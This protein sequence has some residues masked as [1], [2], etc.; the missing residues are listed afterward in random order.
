MTNLQDDSS[1]QITLTGKY[2]EKENGK[3]IITFNL[4]LGFFKLF[5]IVTIPDEG[6]E[7]SPVYVK[8]RIKEIHNESS[9]E[10]LGNNSRNSG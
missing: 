9:N 2:K 1:P 5:F 4:I 7:F 3:D 8:F 6:E 10:A